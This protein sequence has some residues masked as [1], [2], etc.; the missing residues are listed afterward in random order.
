MIGYHY[1]TKKDAIIILQEGLKPSP[2]N[3]R[4]YENFIQVLPFTDNG[5]I[6]LYEE[7]QT[8]NALIGMIMHVATHHCCTEVCCLEV[9]YS[10]DAS[11][12]VLAKRQDDS[13]KRLKHTLNAGCCGHDNQTI[14]LVITPVPPKQIKVIGL[15][16]LYDTIK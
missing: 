7:L 6:W 4:H 10:E 3:S 9:E 12:S 13:F 15:W 1:T 5:V 16:D 11:V 2:L 14:D 8:D